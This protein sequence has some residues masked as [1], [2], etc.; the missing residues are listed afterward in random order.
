MHQTK[1]VLAQNPE[2]IHF[3]L[4][5]VLQDEV[6]PVHRVLDPLGHV[7]NE[8]LDGEAESYQTIIEARNPWLKQGF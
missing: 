3:L 4:L 2:S 1:T 5:L 6:V 8:E 7:R